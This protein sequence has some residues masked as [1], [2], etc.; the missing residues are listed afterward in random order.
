MTPSLSSKLHS[1]N[2]YALIIRLTATHNGRLSPPFIRHGYYNLSF[3]PWAHSTQQFCQCDN[4]NSQICFR[5]QKRVYQGKGCF[6]AVK[7]IDQNVSINQFHRH[8]ALANRLTDG[9]GE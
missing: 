8:L 7:K 9:L 5:D 4:R 3:L 2:L 1:P 6:I